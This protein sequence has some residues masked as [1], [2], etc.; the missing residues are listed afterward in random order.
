MA[1]DVAIWRNKWTVF[2]RWGHLE[3]GGGHYGTLCPND[4]PPR[5]KS[6][7][8]LLCA[9]IRRGGALHSAFDSELKCSSQSAR[10]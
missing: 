5:W 2:H 6:H 7:A 1:A 4:V 9:P 3:E 8:K 10:G